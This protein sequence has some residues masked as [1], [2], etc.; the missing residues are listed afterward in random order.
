M[1]KPTLTT[2]VS[3]AVAA[4]AVFAVAA[5]LWRP[6]PKPEPKPEESLEFVVA[7]APRAG[8]RV[9]LPAEDAYGRPMGKIG[10]VLWLPSCDSC[11]KIGMTP[12][13]LA[14]FRLDDVLVVYHD[15][16]EATERR[17][18]GL[19]DS[20]SAI[21]F[22]AT[23]GALTGGRPVSTPSVALVHEDGTVYRSVDGR[24]ESLALLQGR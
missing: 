18:P 12:R 23:G 21:L 3:G 24:D 5:W 1:T 7:A 20:R 11:A 4:L 15:T 2:V 19:A 6:A 8:S 10:A 14:G 22:D 9:E 16:R 13:D 17:W